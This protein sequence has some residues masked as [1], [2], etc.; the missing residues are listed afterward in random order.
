MLAVAFHGDLLEVGGEAVQVLVVGQDGDGLGAEEVGVP[1]GEQAEEDGQ[2][3]LE[4]R[5]AEVLVHGV[6]AG[7]H[8]AEIVRADGDHGGQADGGIHGVAAA[9]PV[10]EAEHVG[11]VDAELVTSLAL[12]ETATKCLATAFSSPPSPA[13]D[14]SRAVWALV[15]VSCVVKVLEATMKRVSRGRGR[16]TASA[17]W[18]P[19][20]LETKRKVRSRWRVVA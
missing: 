2:I 16:W 3:F 6:E 15:M 17:K 19:S 10:P 1:D 9:D 14:Q 13:S 12:V 18:V 8:V 7:E 11:G 5:G 4:R 20:T